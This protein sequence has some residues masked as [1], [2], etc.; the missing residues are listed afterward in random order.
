M[1]DYERKD[2]SGFPGIAENLPCCFYIARAE[3]PYK[4]LYANDEMMRVYDCR[5]YEELYRHIEGKAPNFIA[6]DDRARV[7]QEVSHALLERHGRFSHIQGHLFTRT[8][9]IRYADFAGHLVHTQAYGNVLYCTLQE[10]DVPQP[11]QVIDRDIRDYI[12]GHL[13]EAID[14]HWIQVYY[15]P[16]IRTLTG[17]L[18]GMEA[19]ARWVDPQIGF[20]SPASFIPVLEQVRLIH[21]LDAYVLEEV[22]RMLRQ[23]FNHNLPVTPVSFNLSRYDFSAV[24]IFSLV[25]K[26]R[27]KYQIPR[28]YLHVEITESALAENDDAV[29]QAVDRLRNEGYEIWLDDFGSGYSSLNILKDYTVDLIKLDMGFLRSFTEKSRDIICSVIDMAKELGIKTLAEGVET[30]EHAEFLASIGCGR[31]QGYLYG[32]PQPL[33]GTLAHIEADARRTE[34][35]KWCHYYDTASMAI[36]QTDRTSA[37]F[38]LH[39]DGYLHFLYVNKPYRQQLHALGYSCQDVEDMFNR[40]KPSDLAHTFREFIDQSRQSGRPESFC[41]VENGD[42]VNIRLR[43]VCEMNQ[44]V[45]IHSELEN[46]SKSAANLQRGKLDDNLRYLYTMFE[47][48][49]LVDLKHHKVE[50]LYVHDSL[51]QLEQAAQTGDLHDILLSVS[52]AYIYEEDQEGYMAFFNPDT[53][54]ARIQK[55][56]Y[57]RLEHCFRM[58]DKQ[59]NYVWQECVV[60]LL[61]NGR[62]KEAPL[63]L[64]ATKS[65]HAPIAPS[66]SHEAHHPSLDA[67]LWQSFVHHTKFCYFWKDR[68]RRFLGAT[69]AFLKFYGFRTDQEILGKTD[70]DMNWHLDN[71]SY[72]L[73]ELKVIQKGRVIENV[74]GDCIIHGVLRHITCYKWPLYRDGVIIGLMGIFFEADDMYR[75]LHQNLPSPYEDPITGLHNRQGFLG[76]LLQYQEAYAIDNQPYTLILLESRFDERIQRSYGSPLL[77]ALIR[78]EASILR[79]LVGKDSV[80]ARVQHAMFAILRR[81]N[82]QKDAMDSEVLAHTIQSHLQSIHQI[83]GNPVTVNFQYSI[84]HAAD[85]AHHKTTGRNASYIYRLA[86]E[87]LRHGH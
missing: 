15:Q 68:E 8:S 4:L 80:I 34:P 31:Q 12:V 74:A 7:E 50:P 83:D 27:I 37:L 44:H 63:L 60:I 21:Q 61:N 69:D 13:Q 79:D 77:R 55:S 17:E 36:R 64:T 23:R 35:R 62:E 70:E 2:L 32:K 43:I 52:R 78:K 71:N 53:I 73:D 24:D 75:K 3:K 48:I 47:Y 22:C 41:Y 76:D 58:R 38:D 66:G 29:H 5:S 45:L 9:R 85:L 82:S 14:N 54:V 33:V 30:Q 11:G 72:R 18:C 26:T 39:K 59:G 57:G 16:V 10:I 28:D 1:M 67:L 56:P 20:L 51:F 19:L 49:N 65:I 42:Y 40:P 84:V 46:I 87:R 86:L 25:E 6:L 81:E